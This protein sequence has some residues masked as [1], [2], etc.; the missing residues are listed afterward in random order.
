[1]AGGLRSTEPAADLAVAAALLSSVS[2]LPVPADAVVFGEVGLSGEIRAVP[3]PDLR[4][5]EASKL[6][7]ARAL[8]PPRHVNKKS[9]K[10]ADT[11]LRLS[12][13]GHLKT[14]LEMFGLSDKRDL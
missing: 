12:E 13:I 8:I 3:Q 10:E 5:K 11:V 1:M 7:F 9:V 2:Q 14:L 4:L 6:G